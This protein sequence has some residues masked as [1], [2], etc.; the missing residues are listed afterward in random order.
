MAFKIAVDKYSV[1]TIVGE[2][3]YAQMDTT[4]QNHSIIAQIG[5][6]LTVSNSVLAFINH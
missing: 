3:Y 1:L 6:N 5:P 4:N 2:Y